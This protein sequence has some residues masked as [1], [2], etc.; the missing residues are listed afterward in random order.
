MTRAILTKLTPALPS[1][2]PIIQQELEYAASVEIPECK[3]MN[4]NHSYL[5]SF[6]FAVPEA[7]QNLVNS[8]RCQMNGRK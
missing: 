7:H 5:S 1:L 6:N 4:P 3:G 2:V 8:N